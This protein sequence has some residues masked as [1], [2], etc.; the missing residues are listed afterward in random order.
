M[1]SLETDRLTIRSFRPDD[2][3]ELQELSV[4]YQA[5]PEARYEDPWPTSDDGVQHMAQ[6]FASGDDHLAVCLKD[7]GKLIG[8]VAI[9]RR[10]GQDGRVHNLGYVFHPEHHGQGYATESCRAAIAHVFGPLG[11]DGILTGTKRENEASVRLLKRLGLH[12]KAGAEGEWAMSRD[13]WQVLETG[14]QATTS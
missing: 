4:S 6:F 10:T 12:E 7:T 3:R 8:M 2:W 5:S 13:E 11:A 1:L 9:E 14:K